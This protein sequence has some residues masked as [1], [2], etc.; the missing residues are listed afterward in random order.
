MSYEFLKVETKDGV[1]V[2]VIDRPKVNAL[3]SRVMEELDRFFTAAAADSE[4]RGVVLTGAG[5]K[6]FVAGADISELNTLSPLQARRPFRGPA[7]T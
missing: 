5:E 3:N 2:V 4:V 6:A 1:A 7:S